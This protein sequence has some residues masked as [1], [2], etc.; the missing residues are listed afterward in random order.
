MLITLVVHLPENSIM[1]VQLSRT[2]PIHSI[3]PNEWTSG[4]TN[5]AN[6][7]SKII[8]KVTGKSVNIQFLTQPQIKPDNICEI[9]GMTLSLFCHKSQTDF[10]NQSPVREEFLELLFRSLNRNGSHQLKINLISFSIA[11]IA[12]CHEQL[13]FYQNRIFKAYEAMFEAELKEDWV[14]IKLAE[15]WIKLNKTMLNSIT[16]I[17]FPEP[18]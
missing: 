6:F 11:I 7:A 16:Q 13:A 14:T 12:I 15:N 3:Q 5:H 18:G 8:K 1:N 4:M 10:Y 17:N 9:N 2:S